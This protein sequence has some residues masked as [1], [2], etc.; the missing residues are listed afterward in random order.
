M[1]G[2]SGPFILYGG[3]KVI[4]DKFLMQWPRH[5]VNDVLTLA[6]AGNAYE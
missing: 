1:K 3:T 5:M 6:R 2:P 4:P